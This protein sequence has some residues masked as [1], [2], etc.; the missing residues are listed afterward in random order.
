[1]A[2]IFIAYARRD[3]AALAQ[4]LHDDLKTR[5]HDPWLDTERLQAGR[6]WSRELGDALARCD[7]LI[8][9]L[10]PA[11]YDSNICYSEH[12]RA[13]DQNKLVIPVLADPATRRPVHFV[14]DLI[15]GSVRFEQSSPTPPMSRAA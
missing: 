5:R 1:M 3:G 15:S 12:L 13:L 9:V 4:R 10:S 11:S 2:S 6:I 7:V 14:L 8:A